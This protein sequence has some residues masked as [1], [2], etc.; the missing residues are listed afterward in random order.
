MEE[1]K[2]FDWIKT[3]SE[4]KKENYRHRLMSGD[5]CH[6]STSKMVEIALEF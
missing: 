1:E 3:S 5:V 4:S 6:N 2:L